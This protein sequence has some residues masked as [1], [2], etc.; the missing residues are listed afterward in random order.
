LWRSFK[1]GADTLDGSRPRVAAVAQI[2]DE[3]RIAKR[4]APEPGGS[5]VITAQ[6]FF[7]F[8]EQIHL[9]FSL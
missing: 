2:E 1:I 8:S 9:S 7:H 3:S 4:F 6:E 5:R